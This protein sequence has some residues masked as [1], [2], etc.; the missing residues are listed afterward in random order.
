[1]SELHWCKSS[2]S[3]DGGNNCVEIAATR[4][5]VVLR[6]SDEPAHTLTARRA[7][8]RALL[9]KIKA[10]R[11]HSTGQDVYRPRLPRR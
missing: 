1:M 2:F 6:E 8:F 3:E 9:S 5:G 4:E 11:Q 7:A 10:T